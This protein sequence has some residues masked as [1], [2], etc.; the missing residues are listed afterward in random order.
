MME[1]LRNTQLITTIVQQYYYET[2]LIES[3]HKYLL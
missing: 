1:L 3:K 2:F